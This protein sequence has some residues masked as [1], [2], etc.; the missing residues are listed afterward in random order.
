MTGIIEYFKSLPTY[1]FVAGALLAVMA[2]AGWTALLVGA[3]R[4][5]RR[6]K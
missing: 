6:G 3:I 1:D 2:L 4:Y 5:T